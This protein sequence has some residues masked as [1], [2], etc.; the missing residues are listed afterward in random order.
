MTWIN[1]ALKKASGFKARQSGE[2][3]E[4]GARDYLQ[5]Q[6]LIFVDKNFRCR[7]GEIDL[8]MRDASEWVFVEVKYRRS[9]SHGSAA[10]YFDTRK[11]RKVELAIAYYMHQHK[12]NPASTPHRLDLIA[13]DNRQIDWIKSV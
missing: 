4:L 8:I 9:K 11:R 12:L 13:I 3:A 5:K 2:K 1:A 6:G 7:G 10:E